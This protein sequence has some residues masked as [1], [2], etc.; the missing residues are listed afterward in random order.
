MMLK[1]FY[2]LLAIVVSIL[3][4]LA[5]DKYMEPDFQSEYRAFYKNIWQEA[6]SNGLNSQQLAEL[7]KREAQFSYDLKNHNMNTHVSSLV[8]WKIIA[9]GV[10]MLAMY[11]FS[12]FLKLQNKWEVLGYSIILAIT[13]IYIVGVVSALLISLV[14]LVASLKKMIKMNE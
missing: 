11:I 9:H 6:G 2:M 12:R 10:V 7:D 3:I 14:F 13:I 1:P 5:P 4:L 8:N